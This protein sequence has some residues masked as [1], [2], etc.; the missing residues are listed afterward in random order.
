MPVK[1]KQAYNVDPNA[2]NALNDNDYVAFEQDLSGSASNSWG[3]KLSQLVSYLTSKFYTR[4]ESDA[5]LDGK[6]PLITSPTENYAV[7]QNANGTVKSA[8]LPLATINKQVVAVPDWAQGTSEL[9]AHGLSVVPDFVHLSGTMQSTVHG[10][11]AGDVLSLAFSN[12]GD[13][14]NLSALAIVMDAANFQVVNSCT[15]P[16]ALLIPDKSAGTNTSV[17]VGQSDILLSVTFMSVG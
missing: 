2:G 15:S 14:T 7:T 5:K 17:A 11:S 4:A 13:S 9:R 6:I 8:G 10:W 16:N 1:I 12:V 3:A